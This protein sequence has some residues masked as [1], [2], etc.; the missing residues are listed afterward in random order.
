MAADPR[1]GGR[2]GAGRRNARDRCRFKRGAAARLHRPAGRGQRGSRGDTAVLRPPLQPRLRDRG[3][4]DRPAA[5]P[6]HRGLRADARPVAPPVPARR[7]RRCRQDDH[8]RPLPA[9]G[10]GPPPRQACAGRAAGRTRRQLGTGDANAVLA[11]VPDRAG[12]GRAGRQSVRGAGERPGDR[13]RRH[14]GRRAHVLTAARGCGVGGRAV[15]PRGVRRGAQAGRPPAAGFLRRQDGSLPPRRGARGTARRR[16]AVGARLVGDAR[17]A[18]DGN[19]AHGEGLPVLLPLA[20]AG[21]RRAADA[22]RVSGVPRGSAPAVLHSPHEGGDGPV[23][24]P[25]AVSAA[26]VRHAQL[27]AEPIRA[28][29]LRGDDAVHCRDLQPRAR[30]EPLGGAAGDER[31]PAPAGELHVRADAVVRAPPR[32]AG[33]SDRPGARRAV[34]R[35]GASPESARRDPRLLRDPDGG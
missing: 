34:G 27:H 13:Q 8:D 33:R 9:G 7:R 21:A 17:A 11:A 4:A 24:R 25:A 12:S 30:P 31:L 16:S 29:A 2:P 19:A 5:A 10:A 28:G 15:R 18:A 23:R 3:L 32:S 22:G 14:A 6:A 20:A 35:A 1:P 26:P